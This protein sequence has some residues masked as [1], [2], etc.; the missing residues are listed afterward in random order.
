[1]IHAHYDE[2]TQELSLAEGTASSLRATSHPRVVVPVPDVHRGVIEALQYAHSITDNVTAVYV[3]IEPGT[4]GKIR[5][6][7]K[8]CGLDGEVPLVVV[9]SPYRSYVGPFLAYLDAVDREYGDG[10]LS[11]VL[12]PEFVPA[13]WWHNLLHN[14]TAWLLKLVLLYRRHQLGKTRAIIDIPVHLQR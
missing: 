4:A 12:I 6:K 3:E 11:S 10:Q 8:Q 2:V 14:Q 13:K 7:W 9:P 1:M 5:E